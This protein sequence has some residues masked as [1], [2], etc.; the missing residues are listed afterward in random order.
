[1]TPSDNGKQQ[2]PLSDAKLT[3]PRT[4]DSS[5]RRRSPPAVTELPYR[6]PNASLSTLF[7]PGPAQSM[8]GSRGANSPGNVTASTVSTNGSSGIPVPPPSTSKRK[9]E[10]LSLIAQSF[11][12]HVAVLASSD[13]EHIVKEKGLSGGL[14]QLVRPFGESIPGKVTIRDS[15]GASKSWEDFGIRFTSLRDGLEPPRLPNG[16]S[17]EQFSDQSNGVLPTITGSEL[18]RLRTGG[19]IAQIEEVVDRHLSFAEIQ[20]RVDASTLHAQ[21]KDSVPG[22]SH[23]ISPFYTMYLRRLL[24]GLPMS[25]HETFSHPVAC[26][27]AIS[28][29]S[30]SPI[31]ELRRLYA[32]TNTGDNRLPQ[33]VNNDYLRYY[34][35]IHDEDNDDIT[36]STGLYEQMKRHFG[37]HCHLLRLRSNQCIASDDDSSRLPACEWLSAAE[38]LLDIQK[39]GKTYWSCR[40]EISR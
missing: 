31:E 32:S 34:L 10:P 30:K 17:L 13:A 1:M 35:L 18:A 36:K 2:D 4:R 28:S 27:I 33:W 24:S 8:S 20:S 7:T 9:E 25:P 3:P 21:R 22:P 29:R 14:L 40:E 37:L 11:V 19:D 16:R 26:V 5:L 6:P 12:P 38:V 23:S 39:R 15:N